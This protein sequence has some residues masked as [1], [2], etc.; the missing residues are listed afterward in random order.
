MFYIILLFL[1]LVFLGPIVFILLSFLIFRRKVGSFVNTSQMQDIINSMIKKMQSGQNT[2]DSKDF[3]EHD[4]DTNNFNRNNNN[5]NSNGPKRQN[6]N[7]MSK[8]EALEIL[9][10]PEG[11]TREEINNIYHKLIQKIHPDKGGSH[12][13]A[14]QLNKARDTLLK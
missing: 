4:P 7:N 11:A 2:F 14:Q 5:S 13:L 3:Y 9:G 10:L 8:K 6:N 1:A 12:Y